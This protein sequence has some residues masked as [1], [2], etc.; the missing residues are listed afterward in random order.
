MKRNIK[1]ILLQSAFTSEPM[2]F[3]R[4]L[5]DQFNQQEFRE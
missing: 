4:N 1:D 3:S 2:T 5:T